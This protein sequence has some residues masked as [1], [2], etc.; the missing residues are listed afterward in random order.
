MKN[1]GEYNSPHGGIRSSVYLLLVSVLC[2]LTHTAGS[3]AGNRVVCYYTNWSV[4]RPA[5]A[6]FNPQNINPY[7]CTHLIYAFGGFTKD[8][9]LK[10][11]DKYQDIEQGGYAKFTGL[12]TY[13]KN[14]KCILAIGGWN[15]ASSRFSPMVASPERRQQFVRNTIKFLRQN[16]FDGLDLDWEYPAFRDGGKP[17]DRENYAQ[18]VQELREEFDRE[19]KKTGRTRLL[20]TMAVPAGTEYIEKGYDIPKLN[21]YLDWFNLLTYDYHSAFEPAVNHHSPLL[22]LQEDDEYNFEAELNIDYTIKFYLNQGADRD[23]LVVGIPTY[24]RTYTL[25]NPDATD[26][27]SPSDGPGAQGDATR[28]KG[29]LSYYE[30]C[31]MIKDDPEW[32]VVQPD[33]KAM[34]PYAFKGNQW[35]GYDDEAIARR[36]AEYVAANGLG[37]IMFWSIDNDDFRGTCN[38]KPYPIIEAAKDSLYLNLGSSDND[39]ITRNRKKNTSR[40]RTRPSHKNRFGEED[41]RNAISRTTNRRKPGHRR[42][43]STTTTTTTTTTTPEPEYVSLRTSTTP[44][45]PTT[46][47][48]GSDFKCEDEGF[49]PHPRDCKKYF[50]CLD[51]GPSNLGIVAHQFTC[52]SGLFFNKA[53]DSCDYSRNVICSKPKASSSTSSSSTT[54]SSTT[55]APSTTT[56]KAPITAATSKYTFLRASLTTTT[57]EAPVYDDDYEYDDDEEQD[58]RD[59]VDTEDAE[60]PKVIKELIDLIKKAGGLEE[61]EKQ[62][63]TQ[64]NDNPQE[65][66]T[67]TAASIS[68]SL[69]DKILS[70]ASSSNLE[71]FKN[72]FS[73]SPSGNRV[74]STSAQKYTPIVRNSRP[75]PQNAGVD[76]LP[77]F[78]GFLREKPQ[79][80]TIS[81]P[82]ATQSTEEEL[83]FDG[84]L[85]DAPGTEPTFVRHTLPQQNYVNIQRNRPKNPVIS[86]DIVDDEEVEEE[87]PEDDNTYSG[88][89]SSTSERSIPNS[90]YVSIRRTSTAASPDEVSTEAPLFNA[91]NRYKILSRTT[92]TT[93]F[94]ALAPDVNQLA[95]KEEEPEEI[96]VPT[97]ASTS[98]TT[99]VPSTSTYYSTPKQFNIAETATTSTQLPIDIFT[100]STQDYSWTEGVTAPETIF[101]IRKTTETPLPPP[102][103]YTPSTTNPVDL[104]TTGFVVEGSTFGSSILVPDTTLATETRGEF[105]PEADVQVTRK[106][107][108]VNEVRRFDEEQPVTSTVAPPRNFLGI[109]HRRIRP[110]KRVSS[111]ESPSVDVSA[112]SEEVT[113]A[114]GGQE[115]KVS[116]RQ[117]GRFR[118][119]SPLPNQLSLNSQVI[120][121]STSSPAPF[122]P[123]PSPSDA[124]RDTPVEPQRIFRGRKRYNVR[125]QTSPPN[126]NVLNERNVPV[127]NFRPRNEIPEV[128]NVE[129]STPGTP[130][131]RRI[132]S[133]RRRPTTTTTTT[134]A[135]TTT[136]MEATTTEP[137]TTTQIPLNPINRFQI[138]ESKKDYRSQEED[139]PI[140]HVVVQTISTPPPPQE[141]FVFVTT[142]YPF[143]SFEDNSLA[144][145]GRQGKGD[146]ESGSSYRDSRIIRPFLAEPIE[147][148][149]VEVTS[150]TEPSS[151]EMESSEATSEYTTN[152]ERSSTEAPAPSTLFPSRGRN[153]FGT[154]SRTSVERKRTSTE[155]T[156]STENIRYVIRRRRPLPPRENSASL[157][158]PTTAS[159]RIRGRRPQF[160]TTTDSFER[161]STES[162]EYTTSSSEETFTV[163][164]RAR[165]RRPISSEVSSERV[166]TEFNYVPIRRRPSR[167]E[168][169]TPSD[170]SSLNYRRRLIRK[171]PVSRFDVS[172]EAPRVQEQVPSVA[173]P[174]SETSERQR[175]RKVIRR[176]RTRPTT[177]TTT[178][179]TTD[180]ASTTEESF[181]EEDVMTP[182]GVFEHIEADN[183]RTHILKVGEEL[184]EVESG[185][186][187]TEAPITTTYRR[188]K[189]QNIEKLYVTI[190]RASQESTTELSNEVDDEEVTK[191]ERIEE[192]STTAKYSPRYRGSYRSRRPPIFTS[193]TPAP[194]SVATP[195][196]FIPRRFSSR[197]QEEKVSENA[198]TRS[199]PLNFDGSGRTR[200]RNTYRG[201]TGPIDGFRGGYRG[202]PAR[203]LVESEEVT[204]EETP[205]EV[206]EEVTETVEVVSL[207]D[208]EDNSVERISNRPVYTTIDRTKIHP[209]SRKFESTTASLSKSS[210]AF[211]RRYPTTT[212]DPPSTLDDTLS[213]S[214]RER[215]RKLF[216]ATSKKYNT[217]VVSSNVAVVDG[218]VTT[219]TS[220]NTDNSPQD[221]TEDVNT[222]TVQDTEIT[223]LTDDDEESLINSNQ[224]QGGTHIFRPAFRRKTTTTTTTSRPT[225][226]HHVFAIDYDDT[227]TTS[228]SPTTAPNATTTKREES[229]EEISQR[230]EKLVEVNRI[231]EIYSK[232]DNVRIEGKSSEPRTL[233]STD[234]RVEKIPTL[235][236]LGEVSRLTLIK[237]VDPHNT[238]L[239]ANITDTPREAKSR[240]I[241]SP[242]Y[243]FSVETSTIPLEGLFRQES[244]RHAKNVV[245]TAEEDGKKLNI[246]YATSIGGSEKRPLTTTYATESTTDSTTDRTTDNE[247]EVTTALPSTTTFK[248][249]RPLVSLLR[250]ETNES[251]PIVIS[252]ANLDKVLLTRVTEDD[253]TT[254]T[255]TPATDPPLTTE[256]DGVNTEGSTGGSESTTESVRETEEL[257][258]G[259]TTTDSFT[260]FTDTTPL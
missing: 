33:P 225:T 230:L 248:P 16:H 34:G 116:F 158:E 103:T 243:I 166:S 74:R 219:D 21:K 186:T 231:V 254:S 252:I 3:T 176:L 172:S 32:T 107:V 211:D 40:P 256:V 257:V 37:G 84:G 213:E 212:T 30:I 205:E 119:Y 48:P 224:L 127:R 8:N 140:V 111:T 7:L 161:S 118:G 175:Y 194:L 45:P 12:K 24:G 86:E 193:T 246:V 31:Q 185:E 69:Y 206:P 43:T 88:R 226:L 125:E 132:I 73:D 89:F 100:T 216:T 91:I 168:S 110:I 23:K 50:W 251:S 236:K 196:P 143:K 53:A 109:S 259:E 181:E 68:K 214:V 182:R 195:K 72:R 108:E 131:R 25:F 94:S 71:S 102:S 64:N 122:S 245:L 237:L 51:S 104:L 150:T 22:S 241:L 105:S 28:E 202:Q 4:Y 9:A 157:E 11:F 204:S 258:Q 29:Y 174:E 66:I 106:R 57:T 36:K 164:T 35:V 147:P 99:S 192:K 134:E 92:E 148:V 201:S 54:T 121:Q 235:D 41:D 87:F 200:F 120:T 130:D 126:S 221:T 180:S 210:R 159:Q 144:F 145:G 165:G 20:L 249:V 232:Q 58:E 63:R 124:T 239:S 242:E 70:R 55:Y 208:P 253:M 183:G 42:R 77:E 61:L 215:T 49:F 46:P 95:E 229:A 78:E 96:T 171:R 67:T 169:S 19:S 1:N 189:A 79:Y 191:T 56:R 190:N 146:Q 135:T 113:Q 93:T 114:P 184:E 222:S 178:T 247:I 170:E 207:E 155:D 5:T 44:A 139:S 179:T 75:G 141:E 227:T 142:P 52:P 197:V 220:H 223:T 15:E 39:V 27:G 151:T 137:Q 82:R 156:S 85:P 97:T 167:V 128:K 203:D 154:L 17:R 218:E 177:T 90:Q 238:S 98:T 149:S 228:S 117:R 123:S 65:T 152:S 83:D 173:P 250:P 244:E 163:R 10:P 2:A 162:A 188:G 47:D 233:Q 198:S 26:I 187:T 209:A 199:R 62:L 133:R 59:N 115:R 101:I 160:R 14:L 76:K 6:K 81:R 60:D 13:N 138:F 255:I 240:Q 217:P 129:I 112:G 18:F 234:L 153:R 80:V 136:T 38:G 260:P